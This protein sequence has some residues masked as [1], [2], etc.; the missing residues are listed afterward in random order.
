[1]YRGEVAQ[2]DN[3]STGKTFVFPAV[4]VNGATTRL[5]CS[6]TG[7]VSGLA[8]ATT[9]VE[10]GVLTASQYVV[11]ILVPSNDGVLASTSTLGFYAI[12]IGKWK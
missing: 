7:I 12:A 10:S 9:V 2:A 11:K 5:V 4:F 6:P 3:S 8:H 1:M